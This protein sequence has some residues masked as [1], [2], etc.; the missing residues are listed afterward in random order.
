MDEMTCIHGLV[1]VVVRGEVVWTA[2]TCAPCD[3]WLRGDTC[4][5]AERTVSPAA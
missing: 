4:A 3:A 5:P 2:H 1:Y